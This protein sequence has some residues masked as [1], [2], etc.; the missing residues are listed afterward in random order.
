MVLEI[1]S[2]NYIGVTDLAATRTKKG[3]KEKKDAMAVIN[4]HIKTQEFAKVYLLYGDERYLVNQ[5]RDKLVNALISSD[6]SLNFMKF[7]GKGIDTSELIS[8]CSELPFFAERR[9]A[10]VENS[11][12][13][14]SSNEELAKSL[15]T[16][17]DTSVI[18]FVEMEVDTRYKLFKAVD[19]LGETLKFTTPDEKML[20]AW[21]R[22]LFHEENIDI[23]APAVYRLIESA[24]MDMNNIRNEADKLISYA[25]DKKAVDVH[26]VDLLCSQSMESR[27]F[28]MVD[29]IIAGQK[30]K[31]SRLYHDLIDNKEAVI[32]INAGI[33]GQFNRLLLVKMAG[34]A[35]DA[36]IAKAAGCP[37]WAVKNYRAQCRSYTMEELR[38]IVERCQ[39]FDY[40][41]KTGQTMDVSEMEVMIVELSGR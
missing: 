40:R 25:A 16:I 6:D 18:V 11:G 35:P 37:V 38:R 29:Y 30:E 10:L 26:D 14:K 8:F 23:A 3:G 24:N 39:E 41:L 17:E 34:N 22:S 32:R 27:V 21:V 1:L 28:Q 2:R 9:V 31:A 4:S 7:A 15:E 19:K 12:L 13:F 20:V 33:M 36:D 5:Y